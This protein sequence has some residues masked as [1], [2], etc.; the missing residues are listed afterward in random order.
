MTAITK[1]KT[2]TIKKG[3]EKVT[4]NKKQIPKV[5]K[6]V[7]M[8]AG[9]TIYSLAEELGVNFSSVSY[10]ENGVKHPRHKMIMQLEDIFKLTYRE[11]F[12]DLTPAE[13]LKVEEMEKEMRRQQFEKDAK[14]S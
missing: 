1:E 2:T 7:R 4:N 3:D 9:Y 12:T 6:M 10:W 8:E 14:N 5:L 13:V 11:L